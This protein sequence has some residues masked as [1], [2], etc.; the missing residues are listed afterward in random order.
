MSKKQIA[1][2][3]TSTGLAIIFG[4]SFY[5]HH[6]KVQLQDCLDYRN[7]VL[8]TSTGTTYTVIDSNKFNCK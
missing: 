4:S 1:L 6:T 3:I 5:R 2:A 8:A 7:S